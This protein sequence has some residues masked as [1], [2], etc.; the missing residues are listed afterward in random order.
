MVQRCIYFANDWHKY[1]LPSQVTICKNHTNVPSGKLTGLFRW[2]E[3]NPSTFTTICMETILRR[4]IFIT[5]E[6]NHV[7]IEATEGTPDQQPEKLYCNLSY[8]A[9]RPVALTQ[10]LCDVHLPHKWS[11]HLLWHTS[12]ITDKSEYLL[13]N[14]MAKYDCR[15]WL[16]FHFCH[17]LL[18]CSE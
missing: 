10:D 18:L 9:S 2:K 4:Q 14:N 15:L 17:K 3:N 11:S 12:R 13:K 6:A 7:T 8:T 16:H 5:I 1:V